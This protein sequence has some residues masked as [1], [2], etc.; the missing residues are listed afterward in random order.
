MKGIVFEGGGTAAYCHIGVLKYIQTNKNTKNLDFKYYAG[1]S[2]GSIIAVFA[3]AGYSFEN[4]EII[5]K[6]IKIPET[7][8]VS[9]CF[10]L[11]FNYGWLSTQFIAD[12]ITEYFGNITLEDFE[13]KYKKALVITACYDFK[14]VYFTS[15]AENKTTLV[16][17]AVA[18]S[19]SF[20]YVFQ[21]RDG[22]SDGGI[23]NNFPYIY[24]ENLIGSKNIL[25]VYLE[26]KN[27]IKPKESKNIFAF[28]INLFNT[29]ST[30]HSLMEIP[31]KDIKNIITVYTTIGTFDINDIELG[32]SDGY[33]SAEK[34]FKYN[35]FKNYRF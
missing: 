33:K 9:G 34:Y 31:K 17:E 18:R 8:F 11:L 20:P 12:L 6:N 13:K 10:N 2:S 35:T 28:T 7:N 25:G 16:S 14:E 27:E 22:Y 26:R 30:D 32:I 23:L 15:F 29:M 21:L 1:S 24:L 5:A 19:C 3:A 4:I